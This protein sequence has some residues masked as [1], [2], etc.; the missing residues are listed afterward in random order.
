MLNREGTDVL[1]LH[2]PLKSEIRRNGQKF[3]LSLVGNIYQVDEVSAFL[4]T[5][6]IADLW[7]QR[8]GHLNYPV[9]I[10]FLKRHGI[11]VPQ[12]NSNFCRVCAEAKIYQRNY[13]RRSSS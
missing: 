7:H 13:R 10:S 5:Q 4:A 9:T 8:L 1:F 3:G 11:S 12:T 2:I 6:N